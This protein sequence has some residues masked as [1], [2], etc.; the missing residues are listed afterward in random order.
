MRPDPIVLSEPY[1]ED[2]LGLIERFKPLGIQDFTSQGPIEAL[3][4]CS[5]PRATRINV[6]WLDA[7]FGQLVL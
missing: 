7:D 2:G 3:I 5:L 4:A 1:T 6:Q